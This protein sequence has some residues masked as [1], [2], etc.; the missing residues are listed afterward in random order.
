[1]EYI[2]N[3]FLPTILLLSVVPDLALLAAYLLRFTLPS[4]FGLMR[5]PISERR[6]SR[7][8]HISAQRIFLSQISNTRLYSRDDSPS[9]IWG[10]LQML[11]QWIITCFPSIHRFVTEETDNIVRVGREGVIEETS[12][13]KLQRQLAGAIISADCN[14]KPPALT[15]ICEAILKTWELLNSRL[16]LFFSLAHVKSEM[17]QGDHH[18]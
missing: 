15:R 8:N 13:R 4:F 6:A 14:N 7:L 1:L 10:V 17:K 12:F 5:P 11:H 18:M 9:T 3:Q 2:S 16:K